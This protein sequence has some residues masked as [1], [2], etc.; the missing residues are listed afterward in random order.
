MSEQSNNSKSSDRTAKRTRRRG[1]L[2]VTGATVVATGCL[3]VFDGGGSTPDSGTPGT[4]DDEY[5]TVPPTTTFARE[6]GDRT[7]FP[8]VQ[9]LG[10]GSGKLLSIYFDYAHDASVRWWQE[11][12]PKIQDLTQDGQIRLDIGMYPV[13]VSKWSVMIPSAA[14]TVKHSHGND[15]AV[16]FHQTLVAE[17]PEYS[18]SLLRTTAESVG[19]DPATIEKAARNRY[20]RG[21]AFDTKDFVKREY[22]KEYGRDDLPVAVTADGPLPDATAETI[23]DQYTTVTEK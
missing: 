23:R 12:Y 6:T 9:P 18:F 19:A 14:L 8:I 10:I 7:P 1:F 5:T 13:P 3:G 20:R 11:T 22:G 4:P 2:A 15:A 17:G 21:A 16:E